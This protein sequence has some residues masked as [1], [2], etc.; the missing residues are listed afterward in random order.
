MAEDIKTVVTERK[1]TTTDRQL[2]NVEVVSMPWWKIVLVRAGRVYLMSVVGLL[3]AVGTGAASASGV[4]MP[5]GDFST[6]LVACLGAS[7]G[8]AVVS[9]LTNGAELLARLDQTNPQM[10]G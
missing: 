4:Q 9:L 2:Q 6:L 10:R 7:L 5:V 1:E 8:P 3:G